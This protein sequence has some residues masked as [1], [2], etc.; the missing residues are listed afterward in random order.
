MKSSPNCPVL[1]SQSGNSGE[2]RHVSSD[3]REIMHQGDGRNLQIH[4]P[5]DTSP[6]LQ[7]VTN[8]SILIRTAIIKGKRNHLVQRARNQLLSGN[9]IHVFLR[10]M[11]ELGSDRRT[12]G[13]IHQGSLSEPINQPTIPALKQLNPDIAVEQ[14]AHHQVLAGGKGSSGGRSNSASPRLPMMSANSGI[15]RFISSMLGSCF[16]PSTSEIAARTRD[17][18]A[19]AFSGSKRSKVRSNS[20]AIVLTP[21]SCY[22]GMAISTSHFQTP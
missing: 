17:S 10:A 9:G 11:H 20:M 16:G 21:A 18:S 6:S 5:D 8:H 22:G 15:R 1:D 13:Q 2:F 12:S 3:Q 14:V 4:R 19:R 7:I